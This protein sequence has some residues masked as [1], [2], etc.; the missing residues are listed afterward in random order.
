MKQPDE[1]LVERIYQA[2]P[3]HIAKKNAL[4]AIRNACKDK[5]TIEAAGEMPTE[6]FLLIAASD[7]CEYCESVKKDKKYIPLPATWFNGARWE[8]EDFV[9]WRQKQNCYQ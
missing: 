2:Y 6:N 1:V 7:Y 9:E 8:D 4:R 3:K 5:S